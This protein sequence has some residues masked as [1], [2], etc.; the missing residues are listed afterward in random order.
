MTRA[1]GKGEALGVKIGESLSTMKSL[2]LAPSSVKSLSPRM[3]NGANLLDK[4]MLVLWALL[5]RT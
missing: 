3:S 2:G 5:S 4:E 1:L